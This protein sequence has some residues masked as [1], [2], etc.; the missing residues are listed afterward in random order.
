MSISMKNISIKWKIIGNSIILLAF[1][2]VMGFYS[3]TSMNQIGVEVKSIA[4]I[5]IPTTE[6]LSAIAV[7]QLEQA[8]EFERSLRFGEL[9]GKE[10]TAVKHFSEIVAAFDKG[11]NKIENEIR[12]GVGVIEKAMGNSESNDETQEFKHVLLALKKIETGHKKYVD[13]AHKVFILLTQGK[14]HEA[15]GLA[16][17][18][19]KAEDALDRELEKLTVEIGKFTEA[20]GKRAEN[21][22]YAAI[23]VNGSITIIAVILGLLISLLVTRNIANALS[24]ATAVMKDI[25][26]GEGDLTR[27]LDDSGRDEIAQLSSAF[28][29]FAGK[30]EAIVSRVKQASGSISN[31]TTE[32]ATGNLDLSQRTE[33]Q[34]SSLEETASSMEEM[35]SSVKQSAD[36]AKQANQ[37]A[38]S[39]SVQAEKGGEVVGNA[40]VA[41]G[42]I[43]TASKKIADIISVIDEIAFQTNLL[44]LNAAVEAA[45]AGEQGRGFAVVAGE[46]RSLAGRSAEAAKEIKGLISDSVE[47]VTQGSKLVS[48]SGETLGEIVSSVKKV[49]DIVSEISAASQEQAA[50]IEQVNKA[51][52]QMDEMTQQNAALVE[53]AAAASKGLEDQSLGLME[54]MNQFKIGD[55]KGNVVAMEGKPQQAAQSERRST[56]RPFTESNETVKSETRA[57]TGTDDGD[58]DEF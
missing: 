41:M 54:L 42:E 48:E 27:R 13:N 3:F 8:I 6:K 14:L 20:A 34:A 58:W 35:T 32:I 31:G 56:Q 9:L 11:T 46:V 1:L 38:V 10:K 33:E 15:E 5:D 29:Q 30:I 37:L 50:G 25:A 28:N 17:A 43:N 49:T 4:E 47:K 40:V 55:D 19:E 18:V 39:A 23:M 2:L 52:M 57:K 44:A 7:H 16:K 12:A 51:V 53:E 26:E 21:T 22:E 45:R 24:Q 36:N